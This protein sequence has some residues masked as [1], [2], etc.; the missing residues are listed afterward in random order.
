MTR[1]NATCSAGARRGRRDHLEERG[2]SVDGH[3]AAP[4]AGRNEREVL[5]VASAH[6]RH[7][8]FHA[9]DVLVRGELVV[10]PRRRRPTLRALD[11]DPRGQVQDDADR[12]NEIGP[13][14][15][16]EAVVSLDG[17]GAP[18]QPVPARHR[19]VQAA[20]LPHQQ[21]KRSARHDEKQK[22][23]RRHPVSPPAPAFRALGR[24]AR[25]VGTDAEAIHV[26][27]QE[28]EHRRQQGHREG[29]GEQRDEK[30]RHADGSL[31]G[32]GNH[33]ERGETASTPGTRR[34]RLSNPPS[35]RTP[36]P[37]PPWSSPRRGPRGTDS[38]SGGRS[39]SRGPGRSWTPVS[40]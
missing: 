38:P 31:L 28:R 12:V 24:P 4:H 25:P 11:R 30:P 22:G 32:E 10:E 18:G 20:P 40:E 23:P 26:P 16:L 5:G 7:E 8:A 29:P 1:A 6:E 2:P 9:L 36:R 17:L 15:L 34:G 37:R 13:A 19:R 35:A 14:H 39:R 27:A 33:Q 3:E 21:E